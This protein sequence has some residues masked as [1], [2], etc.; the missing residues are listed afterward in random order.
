[1]LEYTKKENRSS[2]RIYYQSYLTSPFS[3]LLLLLLGYILFISCARVVQA[4]ASFIAASTAFFQ[5]HSLA[6]SS[7]CIVMRLRAHRIVRLNGHGCF[8]ILSSIQQLYTPPIGLYICKDVHVTR[9]PKI[10]GNPPSSV[11]PCRRIDSN[12]PLLLWMYNILFYF[13]NIY[14]FFFRAWM[15][16]AFAVMEQ[17]RSRLL[18]K[19]STSLMRGVRT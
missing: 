14:L 2:S 3:L 11:V 16:R 10:P 6:S 5:Q 17:H 15:L 12:F 4:A 9:Q 18:N 19:V 8:R 13:L 7:C 1:M